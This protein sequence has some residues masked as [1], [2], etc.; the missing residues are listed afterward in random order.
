MKA[1]N[2]HVGE[3]DGGAEK[4]AR[5]GR[6]EGTRSGGSKRAEAQ[7]KKGKPGGWASNDGA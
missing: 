6:R 1:F 2:L 4:E 5:T 3:G 7:K